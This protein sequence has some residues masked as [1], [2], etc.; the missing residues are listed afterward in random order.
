MFPR[1]KLRTASSSSAT[2]TFNQAVNATI[3]PHNSR[4]MSARMRRF[5]SNIPIIV[6]IFFAVL[7]VVQYAADLF[8]DPIPTGPPWHGPPFLLPNN[9]S[10]LLGPY[11]PWYPA[12]YYVRP[13]ASCNITQVSSKRS[14]TSRALITCHPG[15]FREC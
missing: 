1:P 10:H 8:V 13:P 2:T 11:S 3:L 14:D 7:I 6:S 12:E 9:V 15:S 5:L 4:P